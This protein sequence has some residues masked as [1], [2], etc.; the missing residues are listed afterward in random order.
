M[1]KSTPDEHPDGMPTYGR[2]WVGECA[3]DNELDVRVMQWNILADSLAKGS[4]EEH[5][6]F[7]GPSSGELPGQRWVQWGT[8]EPPHDYQRPHIFRCNPQWLEWSH[9]CKLVLAEIK[10]IDPDIIGL[11]EV[12][13]WED[14][15]SELPEYEGYFTAKTGFKDGVC[16]LWRKSKFKASYSKV[17]RFS[18]GAQVTLLK[19]LLMRTSDPNKFRPILAISTHL[20]AGFTQQYETTRED[21]SQGLMKLV[22]SIHEGEAIVI[23]ADMNAHPT[24]LS[25]ISA[26]ALPSLVQ[27]SVLKLQSPYS[28]KVFTAWS[29]WTDGEV[30]AAFDHILYSNNNFVCSGIFQLPEIISISREPCRLPNYRWPSDHLPLAADLRMLSS[31]KSCS[32]DLNTDIETIVLQLPQYRYNG[33]TPPTR[34]N[35]PIMPPQQPVI[36]SMPRMG[37]HSHV[38]IVAI[39]IA[40]HFLPPPPPPPVPS[41]VGSVCKYYAVGR[42]VYAHA[43]KY[44]HSDGR[45]GERCY[46]FDTGQH[47]KHGG[48]CPFLHSSSGV[49]CV[50]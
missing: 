29:G 44:P 22:S 11:Q 20:K 13:H 26:T 17:V 7:D 12:D 27:N 45:R 3:R 40:D 28:S 14:L 23:L 46:F 41:S 16:L 6:S 47:C 49:A 43:C 4:V 25:G 8:E 39:Q 42:C 33:Y 24:D 35:R 9:R 19:R 30:R 15:I 21:Q 37:H 18:R 5:N 31:C 38:D 50:Y 36:P 10:R 32:D 34:N 1:E 2:C 48:E